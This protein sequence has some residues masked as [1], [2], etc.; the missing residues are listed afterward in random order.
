MILMR[1]QIR[2]AEKALQR[3]GLPITKENVRIVS[4]VFSSG[5]KA[6]LASKNNKKKGGK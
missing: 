2:A 6:Q 1:K 3:L 5:W 4:Y